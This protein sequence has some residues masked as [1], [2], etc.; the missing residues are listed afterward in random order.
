MNGV[1][2]SLPLILKPSL[3]IRERYPKSENFIVLRNPRWDRFFPV[4]SIAAK[5]PLVILD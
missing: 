2:V 5:K 1:S 4:E 3:Q